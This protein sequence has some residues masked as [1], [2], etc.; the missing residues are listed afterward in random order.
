MKLPTYQIK[1][2]E[3]HVRSKPDHRKI[4][5]KIDKVIK[6]YFL[7]KKVAIRC[8]SSEDHKGK[9]VNEVVKII[10]KLGTDRYSKTRKG[11]RYENIEGKHIDIF[12]LDFKITKKGEYLKYFIEPFYD[13]AIK[14]NGRPVRLDIVIIYD[15]SKLKQVVHSYKGREGENKKDGFVFKDPDNKKGALLGII[16]LK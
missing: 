2:S 15:L 13:L 8:L 7:G 11:D 1:I 12:A 4:G 5:A 10:K 3:Y 14:Y 6:K 16:K 9:S